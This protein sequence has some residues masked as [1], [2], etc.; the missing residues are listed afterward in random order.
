[1]HNGEVCFAPS[2]CQL[3]EYIKYCLMNICVGSVPHTRYVAVHRGILFFCHYATHT[4]DGDLYEAQ[5]CIVSPPPPQNVV[6]W[7]EQTTAHHFIRTPTAKLYSETVSPYACIRIISL[8]DHYCLSLLPVVQCARG[9][10]PSRLRST[11]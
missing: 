5:N 6:L 11:R 2:L 3:P 8:S 1:M 9:R 4:P 10:P 7:V